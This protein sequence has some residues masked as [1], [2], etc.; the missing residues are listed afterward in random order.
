M[1]ERI[2][3]Y[4]FHVVWTHVF[5][6]LKYFLFSASSNRFLHEMIYSKHLQNQ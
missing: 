6:D 3:V 2:G 5:L 4:K 1:G